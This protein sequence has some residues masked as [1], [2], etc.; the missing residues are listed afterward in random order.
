M[1]NFI[2]D[3]NVKFDVKEK[4]N[5]IQLETL[6]NESCSTQ[7]QDSPR[8]NIHSYNYRNLNNGKITS[9]A[10]ANE[11]KNSDNYANKNNNEINKGRNNNNNTREISYAAEKDLTIINE[12]MNDH[13]KITKSKELSYLINQIEINENSLTANDQDNNKDEL[14]MLNDLQSNTRITFSNINNDSNNELKLKKDKSINKRNYNE[15]NLKKDLQDKNKT[16][17]VSKKKTTN[18]QELFS[19]HKNNIYLL[20]KK[21]EKCKKKFIN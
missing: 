17:K 1:I 4:S 14:N 16:N 20:K 7:Y 12:T 15:A 11:R 8:E 19:M 5:K 9:I 3:L 21:M 18:K 2:D 10:N 13:S 6:G